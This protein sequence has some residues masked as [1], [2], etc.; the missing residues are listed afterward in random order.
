M[1][2]E[3]LLGRPRRDETSPHLSSGMPG[4]SLCHPAQASRVPSQ[5]KDLEKQQ[6]LWTEGPV[7]RLLV[8]HCG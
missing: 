7:L 1:V 6:H 8:T 3:P 5:A 2:P 4:A